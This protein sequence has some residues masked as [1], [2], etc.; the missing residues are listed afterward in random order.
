MAQAEREARLAQWESAPHARYC[1]PREEHLLPLHVCCGAAGR[2]SSQWF[3]PTI[4]GKA[5]TT[6]L[7]QPA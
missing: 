2:P 1:H 5:A 4:F 7:W 6:V 3:G